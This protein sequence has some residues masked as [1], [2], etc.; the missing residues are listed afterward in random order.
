[1]RGAFLIAARVACGTTLVPVLCLFR[2]IAPAY[3]TRG[4]TTKRE[5]GRGSYLFRRLR[6]TEALVIFAAEVFEYP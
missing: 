2:A 5:L 1:M 6:F 4:R 3:T